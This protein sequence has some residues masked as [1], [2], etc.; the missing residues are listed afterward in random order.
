MI[1]AI[2]EHPFVHFNGGS[3]PL[4]HSAAPTVGRVSCS[5]PGIRGGRRSATLC[6]SSCCEPSIPSAAWRAPSGRA[7]ESREECIRELAES[8]GVTVEALYWAYGEDDVVAILSSTDDATVVA[9]SIAIDMSGAARASTTPL[10]TAAEMDAIVDKL[11][12]YRPP[13]L[14]LRDDED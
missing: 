2:L 14:V 10:L 1:G 12:E 8:L 13:G 9:L 3:A 6:R 11:P 4:A 5:M 7:F